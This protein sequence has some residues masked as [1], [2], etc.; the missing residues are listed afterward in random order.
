MNNN[1]TTTT[2]TTRDEFHAIERYLTRFPFEIF[3]DYSDEL[4]AQEVDDIVENG[5]HLDEIRSSIEELAAD[6][7]HESLGYYCDVLCEELDID[8]AIVQQ[9]F[10]ENGYPCQILTD[11]GLSQIIGNTGVCVTATV[12]SSQDFALRLGESAYG[13]PV[14]YDDVREVTDLFDIN[15]RELWAEL[16]EALEVTPAS[17]WPSLPSRRNPAISS[18]DLVN[19]ICTLY[20]AAPMFLLGDLAEVIDALASDKVTIKSGTN[21]VFGNT[22]IGATTSEVELLRDLTVERSRLTFANDLTTTYGLQ[23]ICGYVSSYWTDGHIHTT[24]N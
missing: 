22:W 8:R 10:D 17:S 3:V 9:Y 1:D 20:D 23:D 18:K 13:A 7:S 16:N 2:T 12:N 19:N 4:S 15:P 5:V 21:V 24:T 14:S 11:S 6:Y